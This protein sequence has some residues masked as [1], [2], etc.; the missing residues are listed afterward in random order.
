MPWLGIAI[1]T[2]FVPVLG[3]DKNLESVHFLG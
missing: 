1:V 2:E 3:C